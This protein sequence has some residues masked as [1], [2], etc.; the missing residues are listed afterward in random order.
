MPEFYTMFA[1]KYLSGIFFWGDGNPLPPSR[2]PMAGP[3]ASHQLNPAHFFLT[4]PNNR[5]RK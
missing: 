1:R 4:P 3:Q 2:T 5:H